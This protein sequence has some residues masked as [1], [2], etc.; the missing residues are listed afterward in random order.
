MPEHENDALYNTIKLSRKLRPFAEQAEW[1]IADVLTKATEELGEF[2]EAVQ[3]E[4]GKFPHKTRELDAPFYEA[5]DLI[6]CVMDVLSRLYSTKSP[7]EIC[8]L[9]HHAINSKNVKWEA[10]VTPEAPE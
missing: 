5:A 1:S 7:A 3:I 9:V 6:Q 2:S 10:V 8:T 4:R